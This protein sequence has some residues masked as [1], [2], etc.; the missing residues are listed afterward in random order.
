MDKD[1]DEWRNKDEKRRERDEIDMKRV[2]KI[3][4]STC[5]CEPCVREDEWC[6]VSLRPSVILFNEA[7]RGKQEERRA[8][9]R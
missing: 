5:V 1:E 7:S 4:T 9:G 6:V 3:Q 8:S 2:D